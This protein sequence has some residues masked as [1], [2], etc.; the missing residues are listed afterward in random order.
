MFLPRPI[1]IA[2]LNDEAYYKRLYYLG[3]VGGSAI[4]F[5]LILAGRNTRW[6]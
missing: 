6:S 2:N 5:L 3:D 1:F 4:F